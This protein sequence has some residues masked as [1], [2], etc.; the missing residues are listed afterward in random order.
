V[1]YGAEASYSPSPYEIQ[2]RKREQQEM[3]KLLNWS[4]KFEVK[5]DPPKSESLE[6]IPKLPKSEQGSLYPSLPLDSS[7]FEA[8]A[9]PNLG[10]AIDSYCA[11]TDDLI[12]DLAHM[13]LH[14]NPPTSA[15][16]Q[17]SKLYGLPFLM[18]VSF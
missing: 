7:T 11:K 3:D 9:Y 1:K 13:R 17:F 14:N 6:A 16:A 15:K 8:T 12:N 10:R 2:S 5:V 4:P 18:K